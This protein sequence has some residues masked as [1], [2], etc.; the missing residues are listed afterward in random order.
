MAVDVVGILKWQGE[1]EAV[2][3]GAAKCAP[4]GH[5]ALT[6]SFSGSER[7]WGEPTYLA[8][9]HFVGLPS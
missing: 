2:C 6:L 8:V 3:N 7:K 5:N 1:W 4:M 9:S